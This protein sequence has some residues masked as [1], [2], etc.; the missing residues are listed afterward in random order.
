MAELLPL[1]SS[2]NRREDL[3]AKVVQDFE[4][5]DSDDDVLSQVDEREFEGG[6]RQYRRPNQSPQ[7]TLYV[8]YTAM[9]NF[10]DSKKSKKIQVQ[11]EKLLLM[12]SCL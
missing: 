10:N 1:N 8:Y 4:T 12:S 6:P 9:P 5:T 3:T 11:P 7:Q 2:P